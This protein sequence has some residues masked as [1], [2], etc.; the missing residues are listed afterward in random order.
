MLVNTQLL[1]LEE[2]RMRLRVGRNTIYELVRKGKLHSVR[3]G[4]SILR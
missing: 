4:R 1:T 2:T 3:L